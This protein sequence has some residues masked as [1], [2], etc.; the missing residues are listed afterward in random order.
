[1]EY[2]GHV[3]VESGAGG[4]QEYT[5]T[6]SLLQLSLYTLVPTA[7][8]CIKSELTSFKIRAPLILVPLTSIWLKDVCNNAK[9]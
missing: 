6:I 1:M 9:Y 3:L 8:V 4:L 2:N 5:V 7:Y